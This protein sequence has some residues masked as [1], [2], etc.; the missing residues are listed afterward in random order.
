MPGCCIRVKFVPAGTSSHSQAYVDAGKS[1]EAHEAVLAGAKVLA[2]T[3]FDLIH[4]DGLMAKLW[5]DFEK[6]KKNA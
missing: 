3:A 6:A 4:T 5:Q 2:G 1:T